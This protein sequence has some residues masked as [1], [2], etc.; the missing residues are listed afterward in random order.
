MRVS[1]YTGAHM[2]TFKYIHTHAHI[3]S[4]SWSDHLCDLC[5]YLYLYVCVCAQTRICVYIDLY[6]GVY[7]HTH[8]YMDT[9]THTHTRTH[10]HTHLIR[11]VGVIINVMCE[12]NYVS[13]LVCVHTHIYVLCIFLS[14]CV[15]TRTHV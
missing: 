5:V 10:T 14:I 15:H 4:V 8:V 6:M 2:C 13:M 7:I 12:Q 11:P 3:S 1:V 9:H